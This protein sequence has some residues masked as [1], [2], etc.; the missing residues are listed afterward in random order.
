MECPDGERRRCFPLLCSH[1]CD[2]VEALKATITKKT[3]CTACA[4]SEGELHYTECPFFHKS[5]AVMKAKYEELKDGV[6]D[7]NDFVLPNKDAELERREQ[8]FY[9]CR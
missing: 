7:E 8:E 5:T 6:L 9:G 1:V 4:A 2:H 3:T